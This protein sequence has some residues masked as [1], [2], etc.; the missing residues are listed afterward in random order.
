MMAFIRQ[1]LNHWLPWSQT[2]TKVMQRTADFHHQV[3]DTGLAEA[4][5]VVDDA[6]AL[7]A[8]VH[9]L[10]ADTPAGHAPIGGS[11]RAGEGSPPRLLRRHDHFDL[12]ERKR[13]TP[14]ILEQPAAHWQGIRGAICNPLIVGAADVGRAEKE[15]RECRVD[16]QHVFHGMTLFLPL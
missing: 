5:D 7:D 16:Q 4:A 6:A 14:Q 1:D 8:A 10:D 2:H 13:Q 15:N 11:L 9:M 12:R 3:T